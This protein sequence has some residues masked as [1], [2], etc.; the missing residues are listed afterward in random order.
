MASKKKRVYKHRLQV[1]MG[2]WTGFV[3]FVGILYNTYKENKGKGWAS[4][5][6]YWFRDITGYD[7]FSRSWNWRNANAGIVLGGGVAVSWLGAKSKTNRYLPTFGPISI[8][9]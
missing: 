4:V 5:A 8:N 1:R 9:W 7:L 6:K 2:A 3:G